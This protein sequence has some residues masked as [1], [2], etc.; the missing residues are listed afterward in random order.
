MIGLGSNRLSVCRRGGMSVT[1]AGRGGMEWLGVRYPLWAQWWLPYSRQ[2][3][4]ALKAQFPTQWPTIRDYGFAHPALVPFINEDPMLVMSLI[5]GLGVRTI[6]SDGTAYIATDW[7]PTVDDTRIV[8]KAIPTLFGGARHT[9]RLSGAYDGSRCPGVWCNYPIA[10]IM[11]GNNDLE[12]G[13]ALTVNQRADYD[14]TI[15]AG[16]V[17]GTVNGSTVNK[18]Y[19][20]SQLTCQ[21]KAYIFRCNEGSGTGL[22]PYVLLIYYAIYN[23]GVKE[24]EYV[25]FRSSTQGEGL[26]DIANLVFYPNA[27]SSGSFT[28]SESPAS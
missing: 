17:T 1:Q 3:G 23:G 8:S 27:N 20:G 11:V 24:R 12:L 22:N 19:G 25:P 6:K 13:V 26:L 5:D 16:S 2:A 28:I 4:E 15:K 10:T 14:I 7:R 21:R 18:T 9:Y